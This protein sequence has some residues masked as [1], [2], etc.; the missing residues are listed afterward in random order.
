MRDITQSNGR[1]MGLAAGAEISV[2]AEGAAAAM[3][4]IMAVAVSLK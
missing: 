4:G 1:V 2:E 3:N